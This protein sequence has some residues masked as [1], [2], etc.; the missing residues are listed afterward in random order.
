MCGIL[1]FDEGIFCPSELWLK[2]NFSSWN[3]I[4]DIQIF[5]IEK[6]VQLNTVCGGLTKKFWAIY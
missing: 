1:L 2:E 4:G 5:K 3:L 6:L